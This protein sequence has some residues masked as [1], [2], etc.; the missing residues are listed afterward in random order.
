M[1]IAGVIDGCEN[2]GWWNEGRGVR[3]AGEL[4]AVDCMKSKLPL[5][6]V[7][8]VDCAVK[9]RAGRSSLASPLCSVMD[10]D[11]RGLL[12]RLVAALRA[13]SQNALCFAEGSVGM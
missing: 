4:R 1:F 8:K 10:I 6:I 12:S 7:D 5:N 2:D 9:G 11:P 13:R 3:R